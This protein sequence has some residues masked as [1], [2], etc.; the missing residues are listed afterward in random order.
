VRLLPHSTLSR[1]HKIYI[2]FH[3]N[4][5]CGIAKELLKEKHMGKLK[6]KIISKI[7]SFLKCV[8]IILG[9]V[10]ATATPYIFHTPT[11]AWLSGI[12]GLIAGV[13]GTFYLFITDE[14]Q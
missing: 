9:I 10:W 2:L 6:Q 4:K 11:G 13:F 12:G 7:L 5:I 3:I 8:P 1:N 14:T